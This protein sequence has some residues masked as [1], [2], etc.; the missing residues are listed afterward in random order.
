MLEAFIVCAEGSCSRAEGSCFRAEGFY[1]RAEGFCF[2]AEGSCFWAEGSL[3][4]APKARP[5]LASPDG[6]QLGSLLLLC[7]NAP[8]AWLG[9]T[10]GLISPIRGNL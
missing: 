2:W 8:V 3:L 4:S 9:A 1:F 6:N 5:W 10:F 7:S